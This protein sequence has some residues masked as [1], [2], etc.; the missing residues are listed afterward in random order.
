[1]SGHSKWHSI[2]HKK[3]AADKK[4]GKIFT[5]H[6]KLITIAAQDGGGDPDSNPRLR[7]MIENAKAEGVPNNNIERAIKKGTGDLAGDKMEELTYEGYGPGGAAIL[8]KT[9]T[10]NRNRTVQDIRTTLSKNGGNMADSGSVSY[11]FDFKGLILTPIAENLEEV[12]LAAIDA[13]AEDVSVEDEMM[14]I[15]VPSNELMQAKAKL[16]SSGYKIESAELTY[17]PQTTVPA[18]ESEKQLKN[19]L[20]TLE[21]LDDIDDVYSNADFDD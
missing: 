19:L 15:I 16:E 17:L 11:L 18:G 13:G 1:M 20:E 6:A 21:E 12:E 9:I 5:K 8:I 4:R 7:T 14:E 2:R 10:D 3:G